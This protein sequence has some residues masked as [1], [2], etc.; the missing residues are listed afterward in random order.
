M[1]NISQKMRA[2]RERVP[3]LI[4][5]G[6]NRKKLCGYSQTCPQAKTKSYKKL[7]HYL[8][9]K[10]SQTKKEIRFREDL[11]KKGEKISQTKFHKQKRREQNF[12]NPK[13]MSNLVQPFTNMKN[14]M[15][16]CILI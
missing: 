10:I 6:K 14:M 3:I 11:N 7:Y 2:K 5:V 15:Q 13:Q 4:R 1:T 9:F 8:D 12:T 16:S